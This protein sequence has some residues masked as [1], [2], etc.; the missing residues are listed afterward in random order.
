MFAA[1]AQGRALLAASA[2]LEIAG[3]AALMLRDDGLEAAASLVDAAIE[4][5]FLL[6]PATASAGCAGP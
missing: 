5:P 2:M 4:A 1:I 6:P 3:A